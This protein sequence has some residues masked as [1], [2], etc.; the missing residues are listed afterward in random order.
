[1]FKWPDV[2]SP[3]A[4]EHELADFV[5]L[6]AWRNG[7]M[8]ALELNRHLN[9]LDECDHSGGVLEEDP[10]E[11][12]TQEAFAELERRCNACPRG[13]PFS[14]DDNGQTVRLKNLGED[15]GRFTV[16][17]YLLLATR[18]NMKDSRHHGGLDGTQVFETLAAAS[19]ERYLGERS[20]SLVFGTAAQ[21]GDFAE[22]VEA[23]CKRIGEGDG[24]INR[25]RS[26]RR[27][28]AQDG[29]LDVVAWTPFSDKQP[30]KL[31]VFG[32][33]KT[34]THYKDQL[35]Q[36]LP[37]SFCSKWLRSQP[38]VMPTRTFFITEALP[39][40]RWRDVAFDA[41]LLFDRCRIVD[42]SDAVGA[43]VLG[44][45]QAWTDAAAELVLSPDK[46]ASRA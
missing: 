24:F 26:R 37:D 21:D 8:S 38:V 42:F 33:C 3:R 44:K 29:K 46:I 34:G 45:V 22:K 36:L 15:S 40:S 13:Y 39:R 31:I 17:K 30:G 19:A 16:Y 28:Q 35:T 11:L 5:E 43:D 12:P 41:G 23:L 9:R 1:M 27:P 4:E 25:N 18:L 20:E 6:E 14:L 7:R 10:I 32:Q 2:P